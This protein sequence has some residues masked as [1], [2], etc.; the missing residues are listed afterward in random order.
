[1]VL[2]WEQVSTVEKFRLHEKFEITFPGVWYV[3]ANRFFS[4][5]KK[6]AQQEQKELW[7][8]IVCDLPSL[9][10]MDMTDIEGGEILDGVVGVFRTQEGDVVIERLFGKDISCKLECKILEELI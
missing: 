10:P 4:G 3:E 9:D 7:K 5:D 1:M 6:A 8:Q 2:G